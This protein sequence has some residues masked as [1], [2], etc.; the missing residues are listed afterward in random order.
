MPT[1]STY[2]ET[3]SPA[4]STVFDALLAPVQA[5]VENQDQ[6]RTPHQNETFSYAAFFRLLAYYVVSEIPSIALFMTTYL[7]KG[8]LSPALKLPYVPEVR[9]MMPLSGFLPTS[10]GL[11]LPS[12]SPP[13]VSRLFRKSR[14]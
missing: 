14:C 6:Q 13:S 11:C 3:F 1:I 4:D 7:K 12:Y 9:S 5:F 8:L 2:L 10:F